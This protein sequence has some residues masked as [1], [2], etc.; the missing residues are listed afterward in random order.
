MRIDL[1]RMSR[2]LLVEDADSLREVLTSVLESEGYVVDAYPDAEQALK[3]FSGRT[4]DLVLSDFKLPGMNGI[5]LLQEVREQNSVVP[6][7]IMTAF[8]SIEIAVQAM[9]HGANDFITKP[10]EPHGLCS[11][12]AEVIEHRRI[13]DRSSGS[14]TRRARGFRTRSAAAEKVL[15]QARKV[16]RVDSSV[17]I[18]GESG[19]GKEL[20]ARHIHEHSPRRD[21]P[22]VAINCAALPHDLLES[23]FFGYE[24]GAFT[25]ATQTRQGILE[26]ASSGTVFLDEVGDMPAQLQVKLLRALQEGEVKRVGG[27]KI[28]KVAPRI[29]AATNRDVEQAM[30][31]GTL[32]EDFYYRLAVIVLTVPPLRERP[33]DVELLTDYFVDYFC[34]STGHKPLSV[35]KEAREMLRN[36]PWPGNARELENVIERAVL[37]AEEDIDTELLGIKTTPSLEAVLAGSCSLADTAAAA[38][39]RAEVE[40]ISKILNQTSGNKTKAAQ[41]LGVS[42]KTLLNKVKEYQIESSL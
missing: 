31:D 14:R 2:I 39:R 19:V 4:Y 17:L 15:M 35:S 30:E 26:V 37:L 29:I 5:Q 6:F 3:D 38:V 7:L 28:I 24:A 33:E 9:K 12:I 41:I 40:L 18:L 42:Y 20:V 36:Y 27:T 16:A 11:M 22:F 25:G 21:E 32:R 13:I 34:N 1:K 8:G 23:E 10:F